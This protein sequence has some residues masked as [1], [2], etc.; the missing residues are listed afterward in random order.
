MAFSTVLATIKRYWSIGIGLLV[1]GLWATVKVLGAKNK[2]LKTK[3]ASLEVKNKHANAVAKGDQA[4][5]VKSRSRRADAH[6]EITEAGHT[7]L[8]SN[9]NA[10]KHWMHDDEDRSD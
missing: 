5:D 10:R 2:R 3:N 7:D 1:A 4:V 9:P 8:L 6:N